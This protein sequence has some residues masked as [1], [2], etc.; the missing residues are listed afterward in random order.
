MK[1]LAVAATE[2]EIPLVKSGSRGPHTVD[3]LV[4]GIGMVATAAQCARALAQS[5]YDLALNFC[6]CGAFGSAIAL[7]TVV[8]VTSDRVSELGVEDGDRFVPLHELGLPGDAVIVNATPPPNPV[9]DRLPPVS[10]ITVNTVHGREDSIAQIIRRFDPQV[11]SMEGAAFAY[12]CALSG[13]PYAQV[14][15]ISNVVERRNRGAWKLDLAIDNLNRVAL[16]IID[17]L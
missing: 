5:R 1:L 4:T 6:V 12:A 9:I 8:H 11:E 10:G 17:S 7:G 13:L 15:A 16:E 3:V 2:L 14:R